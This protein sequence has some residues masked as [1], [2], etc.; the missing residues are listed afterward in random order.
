MPCARCGAGPAIFD[1]FDYC[2]LCGQTLCD[3]CMA[4]GCCGNYPAVSGKAQDQNPYE[5]ADG[6]SNDA[7]DG[8]GEPEQRDDL[9][10]EWEDPERD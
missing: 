5:G 4:A 3:E 9:G 7:L 10:D 6:S 1:Q 8:L 2:A